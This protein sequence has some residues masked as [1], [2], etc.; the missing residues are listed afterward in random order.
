MLKWVRLDSD[1]LHSNSEYIQRAKI[2]GGWLVRW[3]GWC[4]EDASTSGMIFVPDSHHK[5][6]GNSL[7]DETD[8][9][10]TDPD[11]VDHVA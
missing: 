6:D 5:W 9:G 10:D 2:L 4:S 11:D 3:G 8:R 7:P 1:N